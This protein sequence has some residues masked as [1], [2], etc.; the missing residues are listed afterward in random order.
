[1]SNF[2]NALFR[3]CYGL[4]WYSW[5]LVSHSPS[6]FLRNAYAKLRGASIG[7]HSRLCYGVEVRGF[8]KLIVGESC[9]IGTK[10]IIDSRGALTIGNN[11]NISSE[12]MIW[13]SKHLHSEDDFRTDFAEIVVGDYCWI[14]P[15]SIILPGVHLGKGAVICAGS[16]V[17]KDVV[18]RAI[19]AGVPAKQI[20]S[21]ESSLAYTLDT[22]FPIF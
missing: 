7:R 15:R 5:L 11:V 17:T 3:L 12:V 21:R 10:S 4:L 9:M 18:A 13:T 19:V 16:I 6:G 1:M 14:G 20:G 8:K 22:N 2:K